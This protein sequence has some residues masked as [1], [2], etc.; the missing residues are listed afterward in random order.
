MKISF[1]SQ[2]MLFSYSS[3]SLQYYGQNTCFIFKSTDLNQLLC[4]GLSKLYILRFYDSFMS[5]AFV[6]FR[7]KYGDQH[8]L[9]EIQDPRSDDELDFSG[10][11]SIRTS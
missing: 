6:N 11:S 5:S 3:Q 4:G 8:L 2:I 1:S 7:R 10:K 9:S